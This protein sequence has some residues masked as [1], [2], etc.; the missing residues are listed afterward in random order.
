VSSH[1]LLDSIGCAVQLSFQPLLAINPNT[2]IS[3]GLQASPRHLLVDALVVGTTDGG[4]HVQVCSKQAA[5]SSEGNKVEVSTAIG[6]LECSLEDATPP[7]FTAFVRAAA[8][9]AIGS[10]G[11]GTTY[12]ATDCCA[13]YELTSQVPSLSSRALQTVPPISA[14]MV[15]QLT[16][17]SPQSARRPRRRQP[18]AAA[19]RVL[20]HW[21]AR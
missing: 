18:S 17:S 16:A 3:A 19:R 9:S 14:R 6:S 7:Q 2:A 4:L 8:W 15:E 13:A 11:S 12:A 1:A 5:C 21:S 10:V 20:P